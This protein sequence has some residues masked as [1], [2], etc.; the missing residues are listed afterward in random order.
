MY[1][2]RPSSPGASLLST[3]Y[4]H[5]TMIHLTY[6]FALL[7]LVCSIVI[8]ACSDDPPAAPEKKWGVGGEV[9]YDAYSV[10]PSSG[11]WRATPDSSVR[12]RLVD[13]KRSVSGRSNVRVFVSATDTIMI[14]RSA[15]GDAE[16]Q[17]PRFRMP[18]PGLPELW[19]PLPIASKRDTTFLSVDSSI[20]IGNFT[21]SIRGSAL[22]HYAGSEGFSVPGTD[23][24]SAE[25]TDVRAT[26][27]L[28]ALI[29]NAGI[30]L[31]G[32][33]WLE[34]SNTIVTRS[35]YETETSVPGMEKTR[36]GRSLRLKEIVLP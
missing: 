15:G 21:V 34:P 4:I 23:K 5:S 12:Y 9:V 30:E 8:P 11:F 22:S 3:L 16:I 13:D 14:A 35:D 2:H 10:D 6:R 1:I 29:V 27:S 32:A 28:S 25:R 7:A 36:E 24:K 20:V 26:A 19:A 31:E 18:M 33:V 17:M